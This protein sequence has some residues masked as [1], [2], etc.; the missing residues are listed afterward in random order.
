MARPARKGAASHMVAGSGTEPGP[1]TGP[2]IVNATFPVRWFPFESTNVVPDPKF[3]LNPSDRLV[4]V[5][6]WFSRKSVTARV[7]FPA[8]RLGAV[9]R[10]SPMIP[11]LATAPNGTPAATELPMDL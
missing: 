3:A 9:K 5:R 4:A 8:G 2:A 1:E 11:V 7:Y 6:D 10:E